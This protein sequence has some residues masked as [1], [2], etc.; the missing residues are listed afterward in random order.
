MT[1]KALDDA[2]KMFLK[3]ISLGQGRYGKEHNVFE[4]RCRNDQ[5][6]DK[7][8]VESLPL[9]L[10]WDDIRVE[11]SAKNRKLTNLHK[12]FATGEIKRSK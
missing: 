6:E 12:H 1:S 5:G 3:Y 10:D 9:L 2:R 7:G 4:V 11:L 8:G